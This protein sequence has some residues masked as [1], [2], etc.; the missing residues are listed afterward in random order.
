MKPRILVVDD[1]PAIRDTMRMILE[2]DGYEVLLAGSGQ[3]ALQT[4][5]RENPDLVF[6]DV[7][8]PGMDGLEVLSRLKGTNETLPV[9]IIS[10]HGSTAARFNARIRPSGRRSNPATSSSARLRH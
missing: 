4:A 2:Y 3:E 6:L 1:E 9:V 5:E 10:A 7:K 8:M